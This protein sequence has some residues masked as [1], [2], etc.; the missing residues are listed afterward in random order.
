MGSELC[1]VRRVGMDVI[2]VS[3]EVSMHRCGVAVYKAR[4]PRHRHRHRHR[5]P[6]HPY[7]LTS[8]TRDFPKLFPWQAERRSRPTRDDPREDVGEDVGVSVSWNAA[9][10]GH[11]D[12]DADGASADRTAG[13]LT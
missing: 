9:S 12:S 5:L 11:R 1:G 10:S 7:I 6:R 13:C 3:V 2:S 8:D 4:I